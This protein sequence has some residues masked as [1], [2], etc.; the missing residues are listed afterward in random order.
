MARSSASWW[1]V[2]RSPSSDPGRSSGLTPGPNRPPHT[3]PPTTATTTAATRATTPACHHG[4]RPGAG[5][6]VSDGGP[7]VGLSRLIDRGLCACRRGRVAAARGHRHPSAMGQPVGFHCTAAPLIAQVRTGIPHCREAFSPPIPPPERHR[8][9]TGRRRRRPPGTATGVRRRPPR[10]SSRPARSVDVSTDAGS[11]R[12]DRPCRSAARTRPI[13]TSSAIVRTPSSR[14]A[15]TRT[16]RG[17]SRAR[18]R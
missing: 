14:S 7:D 8:S 2:K 13:R 11:G 10:S 9:E 1:S 3:R 5:G 16:G 17:R 6:P 18:G 12:A 4:D 15:T